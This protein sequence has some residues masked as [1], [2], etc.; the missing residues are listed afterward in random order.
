MWSG[1]EIVDFMKNTSHQTEEKPTTEQRLHALELLLQNLVVVLD[2]E[3]R[4]RAEALDKW[5]DL[6]RERM[7]ETGSVEP[8]TV[9]ALAH[10]QKQV[11]S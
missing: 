10:L 1:A 6:V 8:G 7:T 9:A 3:P 11:A 2:A 4:F 5:L